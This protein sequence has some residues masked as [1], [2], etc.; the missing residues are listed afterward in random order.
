MNSEILEN[1]SLVG[2]LT[3]LRSALLR[4][5]LVTALL[6]PVGYW[7]AP[8][9]IT[10][11]IK[12]SF[13]EELGGLHYFTPMEVFLTR[14]KLAF[15]L[16]LAAAYPWNVIQIWNFLVPALYKKERR[17]F[18]FVITLSSILFFSGVIFCI[19][20]VLPL[21]MDFSA[22]FMSPELKPMLGLAHF[23]TL[24]GYLS[25]AFGLMFQIPVLMLP[26]V[27]SGLISVEKLR[28]MR[29]YAVVVIL[30][31]AGILTPPDVVSQLM[32]GI[33]SWLLFEMGL[34]LVAQFEKKRKKR[35]E[36]DCEQA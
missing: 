13:P 21:L 29:P 4:C 25:L 22:S 36:N 20:M 17:L 19:F 3:A 15:I 5:L 1:N 23:L 12:W 16:A 14:L 33:P 27:A 18:G 7:I 2:H 6:F 34:L 35:K 11:L 31:L 28:R 8:E 32:L 30:I 24:A 9:A 10:F 26:A